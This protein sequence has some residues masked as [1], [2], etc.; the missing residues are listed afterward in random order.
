MILYTILFFAFWGESD[1]YDTTS[2]KINT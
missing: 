2:E 1:R